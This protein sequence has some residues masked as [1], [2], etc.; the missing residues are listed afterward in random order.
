MAFTKVCTLDDVWEGEM[1][2]FEV[3]GHEV[4]ILVLEGGKV[5][6]TQGICPHQ[7][8]ELVDGEIEGSVL[9]CKMHRWQFDVETGKGINPAHAAI[10]LYPTKIEGDDVMVDVSDIKPVFCEP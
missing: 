7:E 10:A 2:S 1:D 8:F 3:D 6:A 5:I 4:L 9:T